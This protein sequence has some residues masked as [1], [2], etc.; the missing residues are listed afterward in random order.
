MSVWNGD[1]TDCVK[2]RKD[3]VYWN[4]I[5]ELYEMIKLVLK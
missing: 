5:T 1:V 3:R 2:D 4:R